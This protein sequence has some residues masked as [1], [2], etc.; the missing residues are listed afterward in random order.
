MFSNCLFDDLCILACNEIDL[1]QVVSF[2]K[3]CQE[4]QRQIQSLCGGGWAASFMY[5][6]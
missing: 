6:K 2:L 1:I 4:E 5:L 3:E